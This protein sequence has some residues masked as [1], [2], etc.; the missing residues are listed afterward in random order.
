M[1]Y[2]HQCR[3]Y[4]SLGT[5]KF[6]PNCGINLQIRANSNASINI[7]HTEGDL[8]GVG[9][10]GNGNIIGKEMEF[11]IKKNIIF[12]LNPSQ[13]AIR[14]LEGI[15]KVSTQLDINIDYNTITKNKVIERIEKLKL[16]KQKIGQILKDIALINKEKR[17]DIQEIKTDEFHILL[18]E[19]RL[20][21]LI[22]VGN[23]FFYKTEYEKSIKCYD[24]AVQIKRN[25]FAAWYNKGIALGNIGKY[26]NAIKTFDTSLEINPN[27]SNAWYH[28]GLS[29]NKQKRHKEAILCYNKAIELD[30]NNAEAWNNKGKTLDVLGRMSEAKCCYDTALMI[31][32]K[33]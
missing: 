24:K 10:S 21:E 30:Q 6:C 20:E 9:V 26:K 11:N 2:C 31:F 17:V 3:Q 25:I 33:R 28:K 16:Q 15:N 29:F 32:L 23:E 5:E 8:L 13:E 7:D 1:K 22:I 19:L 12:L 18:N 27:Y 14:E 4:L